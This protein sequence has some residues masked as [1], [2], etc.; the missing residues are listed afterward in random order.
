MRSKTTKT[1]SKNLRDVKNISETR[2][3]KQKSAH[4]AIKRH[5]KEW[6]WGFG[7]VGAC[8]DVAL[9]GFL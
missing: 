4:E 7:F 6:G 1:Y 3:Q 5:P 2:K 8:G 9:A